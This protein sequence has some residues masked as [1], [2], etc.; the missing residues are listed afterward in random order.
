MLLGHSR[1]H[2]EVSWDPGKQGQAPSTKPAALTPSVFNET[3]ENEQRAQSRALVPAHPAWPGRSCSGVLH[4]ADTRLSQSLAH[5]T[6]W[7]NQPGRHWLL[8][9][10]N[11]GH[12]Q[13][14]WLLGLCL[15]TTDPG[16]S[17]GSQ[18]H[19]APCARDKHSHMCLGELGRCT[20]NTL[21][22]LPLPSFLPPL[23]GMKGEKR[24]NKLVMG[25]K[26][27]SGP[28]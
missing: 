24:K 13:C 6:H 20:Q 7:H 17:G 12:T 8:R 1:P 28:C 15:G 16:V 25:E 19:S 4:H 11:Q 14:L 23:S 5:I 22:S 27:E 18:G 3:K 26:V 2:R 21:R 9:P 10:E